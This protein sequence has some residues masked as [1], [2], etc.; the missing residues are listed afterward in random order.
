MILQSH[1]QGKEAQTKI[2]AQAQAVDALLSD[3]ASVLHFSETGEVMQDVLAASIRTGQTAIVQRYGRY[4]TLVVIRWLADA[5]DEVARTACYQHKVAA[6]SG[7]WEF[8][9]TFTVEDHFLRNRKIWPL[10]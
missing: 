2:E 4:Y 3:H 8:F 9:Q 10:S 5:F 1:Y 7:V 6:F